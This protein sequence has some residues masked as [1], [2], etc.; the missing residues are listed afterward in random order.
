M[1]KLFLSEGPA[2]KHGHEKF[3]DPKSGKVV[4][5]FPE[6]TVYFPSGAK[7]HGSATTPSI[8]SNR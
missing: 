6:A 3:T 7:V 8:R 2:D 4:R 1:P 5:T